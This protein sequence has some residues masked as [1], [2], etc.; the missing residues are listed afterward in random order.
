MIRFPHSL[1]RGALALAGLSGLSGIVACTPSPAPSVLDTANYAW[2]PL[3]GRV[4]ADDERTTPASNGGTVRVLDC[5][6]DGELDLD[7]GMVPGDPPTWNA[8]GPGGNPELVAGSLFCTEQPGILGDV[9][10]ECVT[11]VRVGAL[12]GATTFFGYNDDVDAN[13]VLGRF[14]GGVSII[15]EGGGSAFEETVFAD[16][17]SWH[18]LRL[19]KTPGALSSSTLKLWFDGAPVT[20]DF[21]GGDAPDFGQN[22]HFYMPIQGRTAGAWY[23]NA[24]LTDEQGEAADAEALA[25]LGLP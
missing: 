18:V 1:R 9:A 6:V 5:F 21:V 10:F 22:A 19:R 4:W 25:Y 2:V 17:T 15:L 20:L 16:T 12:T 11:L 13:F 7:F 3:A 23:W 24:A 8:V 14:L